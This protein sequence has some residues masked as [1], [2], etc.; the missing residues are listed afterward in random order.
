MCVDWCGWLDCVVEFFVDVYELED[1][2]GV[3]GW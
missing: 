2:F 1:G 3:G